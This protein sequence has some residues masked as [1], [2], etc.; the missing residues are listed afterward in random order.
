MCDRAFGETMQLYRI[1]QI[2]KYS[3]YCYVCRVYTFGTIPLVPLQA[4]SN[5]AK[6]LDL[7]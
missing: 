5:A 3:M 6:I 1:N 7:A 2:A 4:Q